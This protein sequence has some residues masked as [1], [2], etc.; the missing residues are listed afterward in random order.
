M[1]RESAIAII[2]IA[3]PAICGIAGVLGYTLDADSITNV[4][5][6]LAG[7]FFSLYSGWKDNNVTKKAQQAH[8][9]MRELQGDDLKGDADAD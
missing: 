3:V 1:N 9:A 6:V 4:V 2:R 5:L 7:A 8:A